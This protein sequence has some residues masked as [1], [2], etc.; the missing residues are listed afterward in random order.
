MALKRQWV[1]CSEDSCDERIS[2]EDFGVCKTTKGYDLVVKIGG[3]WRAKDSDNNYPDIEQAKRV[4]EVTLS[5]QKQG[6]GN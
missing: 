6:N 4:A 2:G 1:S 3:T 5:Q